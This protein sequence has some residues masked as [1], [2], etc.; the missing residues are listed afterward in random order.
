VR[1]PDRSSKWLF[2][3]VWETPAARAAARRVRAGMPSPPRMRSACASS[4]CLRSP[5]R[6]GLQGEGL[7]DQQGD[8][9]DDQQGARGW[10]GVQAHAVTIRTARTV[11]AGRPR[12]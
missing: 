3:A 10:R 7:A 1:R 8:Q 12:W 9:D 4:A 6:Q 5:W 2:G 11:C